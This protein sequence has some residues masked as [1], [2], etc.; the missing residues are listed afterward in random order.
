MR[1]FRNG[2][3]GGIRTRDPLRPRQVRYQTALRP[4]ISIRNEQYAR[5]EVLLNHKT[6]RTQLFFFGFENTVKNLV[7][8]ADGQ[9]L[10]GSCR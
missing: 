9:P 7:I 5:C 6:L 10:D 8:L 2:R 3:G 4:D 1:V